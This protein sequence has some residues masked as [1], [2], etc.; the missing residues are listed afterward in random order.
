MRCMKSGLWLGGLVNAPR[1]L[2]YQGQ[3]IAHVRM[4]NKDVVD[5]GRDYCSNLRCIISL[6]SRQG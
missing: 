4:C 6:E 3:Y 1:L 5:A 2:F